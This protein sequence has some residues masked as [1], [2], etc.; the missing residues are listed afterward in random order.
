MPLSKKFTL[1]RL[2][3]PYSAAS[4]LN[5]SNLEI[6]RDRADGCCWN[7]KRN[8]NEKLLTLCACDLRRRAEKK[9]PRR[10]YAIL[11]FLLVLI[12]VA[13]LGAIST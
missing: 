13:R 10:N 6:P 7:Y 4:S 2:I 3:L 11:I 1:G 9:I 8:P 5:F 12:T